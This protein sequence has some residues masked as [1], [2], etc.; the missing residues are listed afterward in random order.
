[1]ERLVSVQALRAFAALSILGLHI[2][3][4]PLVAQ[5][6]VDLFFVISGFVMVN[7]SGQL[8]GTIDAP[9]T[10]MIRRIIRIVPLYWLATA[11]AFTIHLPPYDEI[12]T[13][14]FFVPRG[15]ILP[16]LEVGWT[17]QF[18]MFFY[19]VFAGCLLLQR[20]TAVVALGICLATMVL[21]GLSGLFSAAVKTYWASPLNLEFFAGAVAGLAFVERWRFSK[22]T[23]L[24]CI[25]AGA[26][27]LA[28]VRNAPVVVGTLRIIQYGLP[29]AL[30][31]I[32]C[33]LGRWGA[34]PRSLA[35]IANLLGDASY[36]IYLTHPLTIILIAE[37]IPMLVTAIAAIAIGIA[38]HLLLERPTSRWLCSIANVRA[39]TY[40]RRGVSEL[41]QYAA[42]K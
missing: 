2:S 11:A 29:V 37:R 1:M 22:I 16:I 20:R 42:S 4:L 28:Y 5:A 12:L 14:A 35:A 15:Q 34:M 17:L 39:S 13:S 31:F 24:A 27:G 3:Y 19:V 10:F 9:R 8:F 18:E 26:V 41:G 33:V 36:A 30:I 32:G 21:A 40:R 23:A 7:S 25:L 6:G 38:I